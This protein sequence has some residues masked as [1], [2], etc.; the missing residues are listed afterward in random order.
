MRTMLQAMAAL[1]V[2]SW[3]LCVPVAS[4]LEPAGSKAELYKRAQENL[5][6]M[7]TAAA[8][9]IRRLEK[10]IAKCDQTV[11]RA[12]EIIRQARAQSKG[13]AEQVGQQARTRALE[14]KKKNEA[15]RAAAELNRKRA[16]E[17]FKTINSLLAKESPEALL[18]K[19]DCAAL[20]K[21]WQN[22]P[23]RR[24]SQDCEC[25]DPERPPV[26]VAKGAK[27]AV[28][29]E[30]VYWFGYT[31]EIQSMTGGQRTDEDSYLGTHKTFDEARRACVEYARIKALGRGDHVQE[32]AKC[33]LWS[34]PQP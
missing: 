6:R 23:A 30:G 14:A 15:A 8:D 22:D 11:A 19:A 1:L 26:C 4:A 12:D 34:G 13:P 17:A 31:V 5:L 27:M 25:F 10:E 18:P 20:L 9:E 21:D 3:V 32:E 33:V 24:A 16:D 7:K 28:K 2:L 29:T